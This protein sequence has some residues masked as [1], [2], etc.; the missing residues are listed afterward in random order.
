MATS[1]TT[2][3]MLPLNEEPFGPVRILDAN[4][5]IVRVVSVSELR[6]DPESQS[7]LR[8]PRRRSPGAKRAA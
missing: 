8:P 6:R 5:T 2:D 3:V 4:G 1:S 7:I